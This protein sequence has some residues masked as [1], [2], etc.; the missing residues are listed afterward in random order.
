MTA[1]P[2]SA[3]Q[4]IQ[5]S[6]ELKQQLA[7]LNARITNLNIAQNDM[8]K[9]MENTFKAL[10]STIVALQKENAELKTKHAEKP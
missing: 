2:E 7:T 9:E 1:K 10:V 5:L 3:Q 6:P 4:G 8:L